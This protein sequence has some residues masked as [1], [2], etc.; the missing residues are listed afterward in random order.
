MTNVWWLVKAE[1]N[2]LI[3][4]RLYAM[5]Q[6]T[7]TFIEF[8]MMGYFVSICMDSMKAPVPRIKF[9]LFKKYSSQC[10]CI[11]KKYTLLGYY[12]VA[13]VIAECTK[14]KS[15]MFQSSHIQTAAIRLH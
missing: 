8:I 3:N 14:L 10:S 12:T 11:D 13:S 1:A 6:H 15:Y 7:R 5:S 2:A 9:I 4:V